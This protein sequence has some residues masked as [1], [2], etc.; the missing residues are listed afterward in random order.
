MSMIG[1][2]LLLIPLAIVNIIAYL[3][4]TLSLADVLYSVPLPSGL[5]WSPTSSDALLTLAMLLL[6]F[7]IAKAARPGAKYFTDH[8][9]SFLVFAGA[10]A[11]FLLLPKPQFATSTFFLL[12]VLAFVDFAASIVVRAR[13]AKLARAVASAAPSAPA[14][15]SEPPYAPV[16]S[17]APTPAAQSEP[18]VDVAPPVIVPPAPRPAHTEIV[19]ATSHEVV[20]TETTEAAH[21]TA[22]H[23]PPAAPDIEPPRR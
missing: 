7:E 5:I 22:E 4:P 19:P 21:V 13:R 3:M 9:L 14:P 2:P 16:T 10:T 17:A 11:E 15:I 18:I 12:I 1:F 23:A 20:A 8:L 6:F